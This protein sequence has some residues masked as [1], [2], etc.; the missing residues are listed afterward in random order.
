MY[1]PHKVFDFKRDFIWR[2]LPLLIW[3]AVIFILSHQPKTALAPAQPSSLF[4][5]TGFNWLD[6]LVIDWDTVAGKTAHIIVY[7]VLAFL[8]WRVE[9]DLALVFWGAITYGCLDEFHQLFIQG[10]TGRLMDVFFD[11]LGVVIA[12]WFIKRYGGWLKRT[13]R[14][15]RHSRVDCEYVQ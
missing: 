15:Y 6:L 1:T 4:N 14:D 9:A 5:A 8:I 11:C 7:G 13:N 10:R 2:W 12:I 3:L